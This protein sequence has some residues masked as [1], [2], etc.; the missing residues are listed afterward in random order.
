[1]TTA[2]IT[3]W[4]RRAGLALVALVAGAHAGPPA[5]VA[6]VLGDW[7]REAAGCQR[8]EFRLHAADVVLQLDGDGAPRTFTFAKVAWSVDAGGLLVAELG[9]THPYGK[10]PSHTA[11]S[12]RVAGTD[13]IALVQR[14][15]DVPLHRC[16]A[17]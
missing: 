9:E 11:L 5:P 14:N 4:R 6:A 3:S 1:M 13:A 2:S 16:P 8:P 12:F 10:T 15:K 17:R 7:A